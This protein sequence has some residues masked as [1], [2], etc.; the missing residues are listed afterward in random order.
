MP[1]G[2]GHHNF[3]HILSFGLFWSFYG[4]GIILVIIVLGLFWS[5]WSFRGYFCHFRSYVCML[6]IMMFSWLFGSH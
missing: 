1:G 2:A 3:G 5:F 4:F 6:G